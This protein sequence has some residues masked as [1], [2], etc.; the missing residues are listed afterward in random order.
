MALYKKVI[1][2]DKIEYRRISINASSSIKNMLGLCA[3]K[4]KYVK[5][6]SIGLF[7]SYS[8]ECNAGKINR[9]YY[10]S[11]IRLHYIPI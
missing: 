6:T 5:K 4:C 11:K 2:Y 9:W 1:I 3:N 7:C 10:S 8:Q